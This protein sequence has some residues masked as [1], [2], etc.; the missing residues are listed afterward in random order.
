MLYNNF[1]LNTVVAGLDG[2]ILQQ[3]LYKGWLGSGVSFLLQ[4]YSDIILLLFIDI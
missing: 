3:F 1:L 4:Q 2:L